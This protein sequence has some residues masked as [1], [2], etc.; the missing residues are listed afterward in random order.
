MRTP[1]PKSH[2]M[3]TL[4][5]SVVTG[6]G[7]G[8]SLTVL[9]GNDWL[10]VLAAGVAVVLSP[11]LAGWLSPQLRFAVLFPISILGG[12]YIAPTIFEPFSPDQDAVSMVFFLIIPLG[13]VA[14]AAFLAGWLARQ[15]LRR[16]VDP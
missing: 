8:L 14:S 15:Y 12:L 11:L 4:G 1:L 13:G 5:L 9:N 16:R 7:L 3:L 10:S 6:A 2:F